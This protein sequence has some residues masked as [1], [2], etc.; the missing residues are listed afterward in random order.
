MKNTKTGLAKYYKLVRICTIC[1]EEYGSDFNDVPEIC[2]ICLQKIKNR[3]SVLNRSR[4]AD[5]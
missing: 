1:K 2:P 5:K 4:V 3:G